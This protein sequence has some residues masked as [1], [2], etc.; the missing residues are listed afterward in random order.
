MKSRRDALAAG[1]EMILAAEA[2]G[3][4]AGEPAVATAGRVTVTPGLYNV[5]PGECELWLEVR[6]ASE[7]A[8]DG[9]AGELE[10][11]CESIAITRGLTLAL[12]EGAAMRPTELSPALVA[13]AEGLARGLKLKHRVMTSGAAHDTM[14]FAQAGVPAMMLF[15]PS[16]DGISHSP[17]EFTPPEALFAGVEFAQKL[18][19]RWAEKPPA[20]AAR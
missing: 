8:L 2:L 3:R 7:D 6:H 11:R 16:R 12:V 17:E 20:T 9:L 13:D 5:V 4:E 10:R 14:V 1:A 19:A 15:V 18:I